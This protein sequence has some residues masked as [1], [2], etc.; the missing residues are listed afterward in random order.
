LNIPILDESGGSSSIEKNKIRKASVSQAEL[1]ELEKEMEKQDELEIRAEEEAH[2]AWL[3][4]QVPVLRT[5]VHNRSRL[6]LNDATSKLVSFDKMQTYDFNIPN[7]IEVGDSPTDGISPNQANFEKKPPNTDSDLNLSRKLMKLHSKRSSLALGSPNSITREEPPLISIREAIPREKPF[8]GGRDSRSSSKFEDDLMIQS[9]EV[10]EFYTRYIQMD[11]ILNNNSQKKPKAKKMKES[12]RQL[13]LQ[14]QQS[15]HEFRKELGQLGSLLHTVGEK[16]NLPQGAP[17]LRKAKTEGLERRKKPEGRLRI[18]PNERPKRGSLT[19]E[20]LEPEDDG[21]PSTNQQGFQSTDSDSDSPRA[22][23]SISKESA[24]EAWLVAKLDEHKSPLH[25]EPGYET[26][27]ELMTTSRAKRSSFVNKNDENHVLGD[28][29]DGGL[30]GVFS[31]NKSGEVSDAESKQNRG[32]NADGHA[33]PYT[34]QLMRKFRGPVENSQQV[35][36]Q[37]ASSILSDEMIL[38][39]LVDRAVEKALDKFMQK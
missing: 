7:K 24:N 33:I 32:A 36:S 37:D 28:S 19:E 31:G 15:W 35:S 1:Q 21:R 12:K 27:S 29:K 20:S 26:F 5:V 14:R 9:N 17:Q 23:A 13:L 10:E 34:S 30:F 8:P 18:R 6:C 25:K 4:E 22:R 38:Q 11:N 39:A 3:L 2:S 16:N